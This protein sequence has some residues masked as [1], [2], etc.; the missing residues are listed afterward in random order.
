MKYTHQINP[1]AKHLS[2]KVEPPGQLIVTTPRQYSQ[3][4]I[5]HYLQ[6]NQAWIKQ[7]LKKIKKKL[8]KIESQKHLLIFGK[9]YSKIKVKTNKISSAITKPGIKLLAEKKLIKIYFPHLSSNQT[10][11]ELNIFLKNIFKNYL[12]IRGPQLAHAMNLKY[13]QLKIKKQK[14]RWGSCSQK[15]NLNFNW[16][17]VHFAPAIIDYVIIHELAHL[18]QANHSAKFWQLVAKFDPAYQKHRRF[19]KKQVVLQ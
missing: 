1:R 19:L 13:N 4:K 9:R 12:F 11:Q 16:R 18:K 5:Q 15:K 7:Q 3:V 2:L 10:K 14:T 6:Q 8:N 17:L